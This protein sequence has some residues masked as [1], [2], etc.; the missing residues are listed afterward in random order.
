MPSVPTR[1]R[2]LTDL[3]LLAV[4]VVVALSAVVLLSGLGRSREVAGRALMTTDFNS[5]A[6]QSR[7]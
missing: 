4:G 2:A 6:L 5:L 3:P 1:F 7:P